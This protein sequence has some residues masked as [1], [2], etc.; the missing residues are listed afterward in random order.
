MSIVAIG[1]GMLC[2][3]YC[4]VN[5]IPLIETSERFVQIIRMMKGS[6]VR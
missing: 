1:C 5:M 4:V 6:V 3:S 2:I